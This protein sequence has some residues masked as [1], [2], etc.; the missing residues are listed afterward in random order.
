LGDDSFIR[1]QVLAF[2]HSD[3][4]AGY[5]GYERTMQRAKRDFFWKGMKKDLKKFIRE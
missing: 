3:P 5:F 1:A 2:V 4:M